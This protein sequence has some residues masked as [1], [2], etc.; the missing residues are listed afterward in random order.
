[1][2]QSLLSRFTGTGIAAVVPLIDSTPNSPQIV[3][4]LGRWKSLS[5]GMTYQAQLPTQLWPEILTLVKS[6]HL[7]PLG[8]L[9][10]ALWHYEN[11]V[12]FATDLR[13]FSH[14]GETKTHS[15]AIQL[16]PDNQAAL[17]IWQQ[18]LTFTL[19]ERCPRQRFRQLFQ[20]PSLWTLPTPAVVSESMQQ[21]LVAIAKTEVISPVSASCQ[22]QTSFAQLSEWMPW[23]LCQWLVLL[24]Q[25][26]LLLAKLQRAPLATSSLLFPLA[27][28]GA[29]NGVTI[30]HCAFPAITQP[31]SWDIAQWA[32]QFLAIWSGQP[33]SQ[34]S[35]LTVLSAAQV[36]QRRSHLD[37]ISQGEYAS[38]TRAFEE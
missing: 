3:E 1:M 22:E 8:F 5:R 2:Q 4:G 12:G 16:T 38:I 10:L 27:L 7:F 20:S 9:F 19:S 30:T 35:P 23:S 28:S 33:P 31:V 11:P 13:R 25:P 26:R 24:D 21:L 17:L 6:P 15:L 34:F 14:D 37:L 36:M 32:Q 18:L 29:Y